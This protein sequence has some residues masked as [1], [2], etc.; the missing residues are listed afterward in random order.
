M[1]A[2][3]LPRAITIARV[4]TID[5][6]L[7]WRW[8]PVVVLGT[9]LLAQSVLPARFP[10][11]QA[12]TTWS[13]AGAVVIAGELALLLHELSHALVAQSYGHR[14]SRIVF[15]GFHA[16]TVVGERRAPAAEEALIPVVGPVVNLA[17]CALC[18]GLRAA[19]GSEGALDVFLVL[20]G[21]GNGAA[22]ALS[23][24]P[25]GASDGARALAALKRRAGPAS[26]EGEVAGERQEQN[27]EDQQAQ[28]RPAV[29]APPSRAA[30]P[31]SQ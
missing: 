6:V 25:V 13:T 18:A 10:T 2:D 8:A 17:V 3:R 4:Q 22:A 16:E 9:W 29:V 21:V 26:L 30:V 24:L 5:L 1:R 19:V 14:V 23:L 27:D 11:W 12:T 7:D 31:T 28:R 20:V 15:R